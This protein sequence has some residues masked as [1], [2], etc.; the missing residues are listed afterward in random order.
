MALSPGAR[1]GPYEIL[2]LLGAGG[3]GDVY[4]AK[5]TKLHRDVAIKVLSDLF[6]NDPE[7]LARF[8]REAQVLASLNHPHIGAIYGLEESDGVRALV[9]ELIEG[10][11][12]AERVAQGPLPISEALVVARQVAEALAAAH[13]RGIIHRDLKPA[14]IKF[15]RD[16]LVKVLDF[17]LAKALIGDVLGPDLTQASTVTVGATQEGT[18]LGT[19]AYMSPEQARGKAVDKRTDI[20]AFGCVLY[21]VFTG[22]RAFDGDDLSV[23]LATV[24]KEEPDWNAWPADVPASVR[25]LVQQ[26]LQKDRKQRVGDITTALFVVNNPVMIALPVITPSTQRSR[27]RLAWTVSAILAALCTVAASAVAYLWRAPVDKHIYRSSMLAT[28]SSDANVNAGAML[29]LSPDGRR[30]AFVGSDANGNSLLY[31]RALDGL[32]A[33]PLAGTER[34]YAPFW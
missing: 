17:G 25:S 3:M 31:V 5:D 14:N 6:V 24:L 16:G 15:T 1:L 28:F 12:L 27:T 20:W 21:E 18:L 33:Q 8:Q 10:P 29:S 13:E 22:K 2:S 30:L 11:T 19:A 7:R 23:T 32:S 4:R 26:C 34:A 9:L